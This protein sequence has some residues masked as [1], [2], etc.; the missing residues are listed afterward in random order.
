MKYRHISARSQR[1][2][3]RMLVINHLGFWPALLIPTHQ[4]SKPV[5][6][7]LIYNNNSYFIS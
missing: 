5:V 3:F 1:F 7:E 6:N 2:V 4:N